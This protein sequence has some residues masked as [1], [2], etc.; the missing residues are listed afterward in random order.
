MLRQITAST[1]RFSSRALLA[2]PIS[3]TYASNVRCFYPRNSTPN[4]TLTGEK[5]ERGRDFSYEEAQGKFNTTIDSYFQTGSK[6]NMNKDERRKS[7]WLTFDFIVCGLIVFCFYTMRKEWIHSHFSSNREVGKEVEKEKVEPVRKRMVKMDS[8]TKDVHTSFTTVFA[9]IPRISE[10]PEFRETC[11][12]LKSH[13]I[14]V[15]ESMVHGIYKFSYNIERPTH[16]ELVL[17]EKEIGKVLSAEI[18]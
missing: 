10:T 7:F 6:E 3:S 1:G 8:S 2:K 14:D 5:T 18:D 12:R 9:E 16:R 13:G 15:E 17:F 11:D 4:R